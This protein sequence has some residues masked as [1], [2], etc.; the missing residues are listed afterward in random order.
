MAAQPKKLLS[1]RASIRTALQSPT[2]ATFPQANNPDLLKF[3]HKTPKKGKE[4]KSSALGMAL[5]GQF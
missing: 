3:G 4:P 5:S 1:A 2:V